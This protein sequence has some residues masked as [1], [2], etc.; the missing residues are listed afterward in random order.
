MK[1][2]EADLSTA[3]LEVVN[4]LKG[5]FVFHF[6]EERMHV[7]Q[8]T[9]CESRDEAELTNTMRTGKFPAFFAFFLYLCL[10]CP[11]L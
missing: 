6:W 3:Y 9:S 8:Q 2:L 4:A 7:P 5:G 11:L 10:P 1:A